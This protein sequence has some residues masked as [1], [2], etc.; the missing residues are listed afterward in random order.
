MRDF[1]L[2]DLAFLAVTRGENRMDFDEFSKEQLHSY[3]IALGDQLAGR[4]EQEEIFKAMT[5]QAMVYGGYV[6][7]HLDEITDNKAIKP[8]VSTHDVDIR[9]LNVPPLRMAPFSSISETF[10]L[11]ARGVAETHGISVKWINDLGGDIV[12]MYVPVPELLFWRTYGPL[13][14]YAPTPRCLLALKLMAGRG[15]D[16]PDVLALCEALG[17]ETSNPRTWPHVR[18][19]LREEILN[20]F[21]PKRIQV[22]GDA[23]RKLRLFF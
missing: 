20:K 5:Y 22:V 19:Q 14:L 17:I 7:C 15:K 4:L 9:L 13:E 11:A 6:M 16:R 23:E 18:I 12:N 1:L 10:V 8:R 2:L 21:V 3:L